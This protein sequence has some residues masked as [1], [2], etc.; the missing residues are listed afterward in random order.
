MVAVHNLLYD[1]YN[2]DNKVVFQNTT[3]RVPALT[4][5]ADRLQDTQHYVRQL[6]EL[7]KL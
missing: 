2:V 1:E 6:E 5:M 7:S 3:T 4:V